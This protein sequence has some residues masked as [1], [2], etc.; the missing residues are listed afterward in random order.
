MLLLLS[1]RREHRAFERRLERGDDVVLVLGGDIEPG[2]LLGQ[3]LGVQDTMLAGPGE[4]LQAKANDV[5]GQLR[6][7][8]PEFFAEF[9]GRGAAG[10]FTI[11]QNDDDAWALPIVEHFGSVRDGACGSASS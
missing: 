11:G 4:V 10:L 2:I 7:R 5:Y 3:A 8:V 1:S 9:T 6:R